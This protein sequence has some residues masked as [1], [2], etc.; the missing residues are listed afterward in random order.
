[1]RTTEENK[2]IAIAIMS[3]KKGMNPERVEQGA[4]KAI[5]KYGEEQAWANLVDEF[6]RVFQLGQIVDGSWI[7]VNGTWCIKSNNGDNS[8]PAKLFWITKKNGEKEL[9]YCQFGVQKY[10][11]DLY[12]PRETITRWN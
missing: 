2:Q 9:R 11:K 10:Q 12:I 1:M 4:Q 8:M 5:E 3:T 7:H 6:C